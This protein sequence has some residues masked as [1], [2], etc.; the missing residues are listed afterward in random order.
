MK[1]SKTATHRKPRRSAHSRREQTLA[2]PQT[3]DGIIPKP[4]MNPSPSAVHTPAR[5]TGERVTPLGQKGENPQVIAAR[6][7][8]R[9]EVQAALTT[10]SFWIS[11]GIEEVDIDY[12]IGQLWLQAKAIR[13][14][15]L[16][17]VEALLIAHA[18]TLDAIFGALARRAGDSLPTSPKAADFFLRL[19]F[20]AQSQCR[21]T[22]E[23]L[24]L[25]KNPSGVSFVRQQNVAVNQQV[26]ND[27]P[28][29][30]SRARESTNEQTELLEVRND[31]KLDVRTASETAGSHSIASAL[32]EVDRAKNG[33][34]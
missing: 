21:T 27:S 11:G 32:G 6:T 34:R 16:H 5:S 26:N 23:T 20:K 30:S 22:L 9:P 33:R 1:T 2:D 12:L 18:S 29:Q 8:L 31:T 19:A 28:A 14:G 24:A 15:D 25:I 3:Q 13:E 4:V 7:W 10:K 17:C